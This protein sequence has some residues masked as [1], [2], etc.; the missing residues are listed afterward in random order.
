MGIKDEYERHFKSAKK[1]YNAATAKE[2]DDG[3]VKNPIAVQL[4]TEVGREYWNLETPQFRE[5]IA[6]EAEAA[7]ALK[8]T[9]WEESK[10]I[11]KT[12]RQFHQ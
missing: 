10:A 6:K 8:V 4:R 7:H 5:D 9:L 12:A 11:P 3:V 2:R 1:R